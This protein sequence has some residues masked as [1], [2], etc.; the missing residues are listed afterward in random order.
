MAWGEWI[1]R[2]LRGAGYEV[3]FYKRSFPIG[4]NFVA[5]IDAALARADRMVAVLAPGYCDP[6]SWVTEEWQ[7][8]LQLA[9]RR[10]GF[11]V[12]LLVSSTA[13]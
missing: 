8:A 5:S 2:Q 13:S 9:R 12:P 10:P 3:E 11:L 4:A 1:Y 6:G 7:T